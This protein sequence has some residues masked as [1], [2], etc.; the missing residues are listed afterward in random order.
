MKRGRIFRRRFDTR[1]DRLHE[2]TGQIETR[3]RDQAAAIA[4][5]ARQGLVRG[6]EALTSLEQAL[7]RSIRENPSFYL[8][9]GVALVG[10]LVAKLVLDRR[11]EQEW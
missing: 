9:A 11:D 7:T 6:R 1:V 4:G 10:L 2:T 3:V 8:A 5:Q